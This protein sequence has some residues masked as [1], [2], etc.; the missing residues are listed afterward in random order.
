MSLL[1]RF[2]HAARSLARGTA[3]TTRRDLRRIGTFE[4]SDPLVN[5]LHKN[6]VWGQRGKAARPI[7]MVLT[8]EEINLIVSYITIPLV[9]TPPGLL[10]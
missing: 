9:T 6:V 10:M 8:G 2:A 1:S 5:Q 3:R 7:H 4:C